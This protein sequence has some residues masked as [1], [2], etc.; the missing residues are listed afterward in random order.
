MIGA[1]TQTSNAEQLIHDINLILQQSKG[2]KFYISESEATNLKA[3]IE[4]AE[5]K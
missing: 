4:Q 1:L 2:D 3:L 5:I